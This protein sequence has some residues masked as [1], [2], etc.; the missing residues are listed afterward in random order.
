[1][2]TLQV[3]EKLHQNPESELYIPDVKIDKL[4]DLADNV[5]AV[6]PLDG[7]IA[8]ATVPELYTAPEQVTADYY[9]QEAPVSS[10]TSVPP[11]DSGVPAD[12]YPEDARSAQATPLNATTPWF[13]GA[14]GLAVV[15][16]IALVGQVVYTALVPAPGLSAFNQSFVQCQNKGGQLGLSDN[17]LSRC[18]IDGVYYYQDQVGTVSTSDAIEQSEAKN[19]RISFVNSQLATWD[20]SVTSYTPGVSNLP[21]LAYTRVTGESVSRVV[22]NNSYLTVDTAFNN[23]FNIQKVKNFLDNTSEFQGTELLGDESL[24]LKAFQTS[25]TPAQSKTIASINLTSTVLEKT[26]SVWGVDGVGDEKFAVKARMFGMLRSNIIMVEASLPVSMQQKLLRE[27]LLSCQQKN[28]S[29]SEILTCYVDQ[30]K[31]NPDYQKQAED[32][33]RSVLATAGL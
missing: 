4:E 13:W 16:L 32:S 27:V 15:G 28:K 26:R 20:H 25:S 8:T 19:G 3:E 11:L 21:V 33:L 18:E 14:L 29:S 9:T 5:P 1:V 6:P 23:D 12:V 2:Y 24:V 10:E 31:S 30:L 7:E 22:I 17:Y